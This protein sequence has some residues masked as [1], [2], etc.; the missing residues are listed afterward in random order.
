MA[1]VK[2]IVTGDLEKLALHKSLEGLFGN[3]RGG[4]DVVWDE[5]QKKNSGT[6]YRLTNGA[7]P[8]NMMLE[9]AQA[10]LAEVGIGKKGVPADLVVVID[11]VELGN[12]RQE[13]VV[14]QHFR[15]AVETKLDRYELATRERYRALLR[16]RCS[17]HLL[18]PMVESYFFGDAQALQAAGVQPTRS[19]KLSN[20]DVELFESCDPEWLPSCHAE[21]ARR[22]AKD[23]WWKHERHP[24]HYLEYLL[25]LDNIFYEETSH[26]EAALLNVHWPN[27]PRALTHTRLLRALMEDIADWFG[28]MNPIGVGDCHEQFYPQRSI[29]RN[30][31]LLR[32]M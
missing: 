15:A 16:E 1:R 24:K 22:I 28:M 8:S 23:P 27:V 30:D 14:A 5:P 29:H 9:L 6:S 12:L 19:P 25:N 31:L 18:C 11:D 3:Q 17:F 13:Q 10:M 32:N 4:D 7:S 26:G 21:N 20:P 2:L